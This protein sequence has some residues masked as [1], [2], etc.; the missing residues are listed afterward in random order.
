M[1]WAHHGNN[2]ILNFHEDGLDAVQPTFEIS[3]S[4]WGRSYRRSGPFIRPTQMF[5][6]NTSYFLPAVLGGDHAFKMGYRYRTAKEH[7]E[8]HRGGNTEARLQ[9]GR[10]AEADLWRDSV[11]EYQLYTQ[12]F[13]LQ[14]T[15]SWDRV[16]MNL[17]LRWDRQRNEALPTSVPGHPFLEDWLPAVTFGGAESPFVWNDISPRLGLNYDFSGTGKTI[18]KGSYAIYYGQMSPN[19]GVGSLNPVTEASIRF[20]WNDSN[21]D[22][23]VQRNELTISRANVLNFSGNY[24]PDNPTALVSSGRPDPDVQ[25]DRTQE[26]IAGLDHELARNLAISGNYIWRKYDRFFW[27]DR[28]NFTSADYVARTF[29]PT[30]SVAGARCET[31]TYFEP[32]IPIPGTFMYTNVP[33]RYRNY[34][35]VELVLTKRYSDRWMGSFSYAYNDAVEYWDSANAYEDPTNI[36]QQN[37][38]QFAPES[39]GSGIDNVFT[40]AK[41]LLKASGMY[42]L[43]WYD[44][45][46]A[47]NFNGRQ[48]YPFPQAVRTPS[49]ANRAGTADVLLDTMGDVRLTNFSI[50]D[51]RI[52]KAFTFGTAR[53]VPSMDVF[54]L[55]NSN[56]V[57]AQRRLQ[58]ANNA[59]FISGIVAPRVIRFGVRVTW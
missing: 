47:G 31:I 17:G 35:G 36:A 18:A 15:Y 7:S 28:D 16:T 55:M 26:F 58:G 11:V 42:T 20:P 14:D 30:C 32:T 19:Q 1:Q 44:I 34:N 59:N 41:W 45:N 52:D 22:L 4:V 39:G 27:N 56:T 40:N 50:L 49:R 12:A 25:N 3:N 54:N 29:T 13:Y 46:V 21:G 51:L 57:L 23:V 43:P 8:A 37:G 10:S 33:D 6:I 53:V 38:G 5:D 9:S 24:N 2:F 48:G